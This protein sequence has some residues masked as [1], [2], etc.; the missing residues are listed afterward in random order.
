MKVFYT[1]A[2]A[3]I[4]GNLFSIANGVEMVINA[5][6]WK[7]VARMDMGGVRKF[8]ESA[9]GYNKMQTYRSTLLDP[10]RNL[11]NRV[12]VGDLT[13]EDI[14]LMYLMLDRVASE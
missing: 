2:R 12:G 6:V 13:A 11:R 9:D 8:E 4:E 3:N 1:C 10:T 7:E 5:T 14:M